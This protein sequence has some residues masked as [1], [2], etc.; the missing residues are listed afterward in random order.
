MDEI[1]LVDLFCG[2]GGFHTGIRSAC[3]RAGIDF[4]CVAACEKKPSVSKVY[5]AKY[6][7][8]PYGDVRHFDASVIP[9]FNVLS[10]GFPCQ[11]FSV[12]NRTAS[13]GEA[14]HSYD[15]KDEVVRVITERRPAIVL[16]ENVPGLVSSKH[17]HYFNRILSDLKAIGYTVKWAL[18]NARNFGVV[19][20][21]LR[22]FIVGFLNS[23]SAE[24]FEF[25]NGEPCKDTLADILDG[26][27]QLETVLTTGI[28]K[29]FTKSG[30]RFRKVLKGSET[31]CHCLTSSGTVKD[32]A[33]KDDSNISKKY[34]AQWLLSQGKQPYLRC[35]SPAEALRLQGFESTFFDGLGV[36]YA[37]KLGMIGNSVSPPV[38]EAIFL[39]ILQ[40]ASGEQC[41]HFR[42]NHTLLKIQAESERVAI[43][44]ELPLL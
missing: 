32:I 14:H 8:V 6:G 26:D 31:S 12:V 18:L 40:A 38:V 37:G 24:L 41:E 35:F 25:P 42:G 28:Y 9:S 33:I 11:P 4:S 13:A 15:L 19:Q 44:K 36:S 39:N 1:K 27:V 3:E 20:S 17:R 34:D 2:I 43:L 7:L 22:L 23:E 10:A 16:L 30:N 21:R 29:R 5:E